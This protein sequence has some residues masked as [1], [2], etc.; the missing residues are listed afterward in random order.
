MPQ[1]KQDAR[2]VRVGVTDAEF[3]NFIGN[4]AQEQGIINFSPDKT[5]V[6]ESPTPTGQ[7]W[8]LVF[9]KNTV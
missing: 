6:R 1:T 5:E 2:V 7:A 8:E 9:Y 3:T 4:K